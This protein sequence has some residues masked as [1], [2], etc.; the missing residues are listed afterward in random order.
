MTLA[1]AGSPLVGRNVKRGGKSPKHAS[2]PGSSGTKG[3][4]LALETNESKIVLDRLG[5]EIVTLLQAGGS[6]KDAAR[7]RLRMG[8][9]EVTKFLESKAAAAAAPPKT[10]SSAS[11]GS[12]INRQG[13]SKAS[14]KCDS[15]QAG[16][17]A[18]VG[19][20]ASLVAPAPPHT[21]PAI[22]LICRD[23]RPARLVEHVHALVVLTAT[24]FLV[25]SEPSSSLGGVFGCKTMAA[26]AI[27]PARTPRPAQTSSISPPPSSSTGTPGEEKGEEEE[28]KPPP[29]A[30]GATAATGEGEGEEKDVE[31]REG[32]SGGGEEEGEEREGCRG[33]GRGREEGRE[34]EG[35]RD[36]GGEVTVSDDR[37]A[38]DEDVD[39]FVEFL[40]RKVRTPS[41]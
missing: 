15:A 9:N 2:S 34:G 35:R 24:P 36:G 23:V 3:A 1:L 16:A 19:A 8:I 37:V 29:R 11:R 5:K 28:H 22:V 14:G 13:I 26:L 6:K 40:R 18:E 12:S 10:P 38:V 20:R 27:C 32:C 39:S 7:R 4:A 31:G 17:G 30:R 25:L 33:G 41:S 21:P